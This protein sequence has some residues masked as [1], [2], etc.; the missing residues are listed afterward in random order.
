MANTN[1]RKH[2]PGPGAGGRFSRDPRTGKAT[3]VG[4]PIKHPEIPDAPEVATVDA[5]PQAIAPADA[6]TAETGS[7]TPSKGN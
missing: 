4:E 2:Q 5:R 3:R 1:E 7:D 6:P